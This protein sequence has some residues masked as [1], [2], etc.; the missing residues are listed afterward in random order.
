VVSHKSSIYNENGNNYLEYDSFRQY[1]SI[2]RK[3]DSLNMRVM[4]LMMVSGTSD[5]ETAIRLKVPLSTVPRRSRKLIQNELST[6]KLKLIC[7]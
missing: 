5:K 7:T 3:I 2:S 1:S 6:T 4:S